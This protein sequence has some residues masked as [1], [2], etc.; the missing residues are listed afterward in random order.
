MKRALSLWLLIL[1]A[2]C[3][4]T[5]RRADAQEAKPVRFFRMPDENPL[6]A[7]PSE[8][9]IGDFIGN[10]A[11]AMTE[12]DL[13]VGRG[14][15]FA[16]LVLGQHAV[17]DE[18]RRYNENRSGVGAQVYFIQWADAL[19]Y[20]RNYVQDPA[21]P[22]VVAQIGDSWLPYFR[23]QGVVAYER[24]LTYDVHVLWYRKDLYPAGSREL[25]EG[26]TFLKWAESVRHKRLADGTPVAPLAI[27]TTLD[28]NLLHM[29]AGWLYR[30]GVPALA[31]EI[32]VGP[33]SWK[34]ARFAGPAGER[35]IRFLA[36]MAAK[37]YVKFVAEDNEEL[38]NGLFAGRYASV[39]LGPWVPAR[40]AQPR[41][42]KGL[43]PNWRQMI[44]ASLP[45][46]IGAAAP[47]TFLGGSYLVVLDPQKRRD[48]YAV[49]E[50]KDLVDYLT[51]YESQSRFM[52]RI[53]HVPSN[54]RALEKWP[55]ADLLRPCIAAGRS[56]P[57]LP[58]WALD[59]ETLVTRDDIYA[60]WNRL[61][62]LSADPDRKQIDPALQRERVE[63]IVSALRLAENDLNDRLSPGWLKRQLPLIVVVVALLA[64]VAALWGFFQWRDRQRVAELRRQR[65]ELAR[66]QR[67]VRQWERWTGCPLEVAEPSF[68]PPKPGFNKE[69]SGAR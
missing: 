40:A 68:I 56:Y 61:A 31:E 2:A 19:N 58:E 6:P 48:P 55:N 63:L 39:I 3:G 7:P 27:P 25:E 66:Y 34:Q 69:G 33:F 10:R 53:G 41:E 37:G 30:A 42:K 45:P 38:A 23:S 57:E 16:R 67:L 11:V 5:G 47:A 18:L 62:A 24:R 20:L 9:Q 60:L 28:W 64:I 65:E 21:R 44:G 12:G 54:P 26:A 43:G 52:S 35:A 8:A 15:E 32:R 46:R 4:L 51:G 22:P 36:E 14:R 17:L 50:A 49:P 29:L 13:R 1:T 59:A